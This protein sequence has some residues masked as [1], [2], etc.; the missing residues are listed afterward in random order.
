MI[1]EP[2]T[3]GT[4]EMP[5]IIHILK[6]EEPD[7]EWTL[8]V[9]YRHHRGYRGASVFSWSG[10]TPDE[11]AHIEI[12]SWSVVECWDYSFSKDQAVEVRFSHPQIDADK[13]IEAWLAPHVEAAND[14]IIEACWRDWNDAEEFAMEEH[15]DRLRDER[16]G[17]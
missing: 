3:Q 2:E 13:V 4:T 10:P 11:P 5:T 8:S 17:A 16:L 12:E 9:N 6:T 7:R 15:Y 1:I 14:D